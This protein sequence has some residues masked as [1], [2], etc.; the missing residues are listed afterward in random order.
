MLFRIEMG[1][2]MSYYW[3]MPKVVSYINMFAWKDLSK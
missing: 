1:N 2:N 3:K